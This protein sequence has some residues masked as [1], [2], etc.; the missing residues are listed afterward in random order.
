MN[1]IGKGWINIKRLT[2]FLCIIMCFAFCSCS[3]DTSGYSGELTLNK[4]G[5]KLDGGAV[6]GLEFSSD[7]AC[8]SI[9]NAESNVQ[10]SGKY[11]VDEKCFVIF[12]SEISQNYCF[13]YTAKGNLL[14]L[15]YNNSTITL[16][17]A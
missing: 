8:L 6:V 10:I 14:D 3:R 4:W 2:V 5:A 16:K 1:F 12:V 11:T 17:R 15:T 9:K 7:K 13:K